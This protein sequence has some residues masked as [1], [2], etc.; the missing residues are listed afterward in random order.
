MMNVIFSL[1]AFVCSPEQEEIYSNDQFSFC[2]YCDEDN[3][4]S[5]D[6]C[7]EN[8]EDILTCEL[9]VD[10]YQPRVCLPIP[11]YGKI[12]VTLICEG[13]LCAFI[14]CWTPADSK[15]A[16]ECDYTWF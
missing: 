14:W 15:L 2:S 12:C 1:L 3:N 4:C 6:I 11:G 7:Y 8:T 5:V 13:D 16:E 9:L 10:D